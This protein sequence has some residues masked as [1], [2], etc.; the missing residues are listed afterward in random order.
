MK[1]L[2]VLFI[3]GT[4]NISA[5]S[6]RL[7]LLRGDEVYFVNRTL[8]A[9][10]AASGVK[11]IQCDVF[12]GQAL[13]AAVKDMHF[14]VVL[15]FIC[16]TLEH[17]KRDFEVFRDKVRQFFFISSCTVYQKQSLSE[18]ITEDVPLKNPYSDYAQNKIACELYFLERYR[19]DDFPVTIVRP[20][21]TYGETRFVV[22]PLM[23]WQVSHWTLVDRIL[24]GEPIIVHDTGRLFWTVT[25]SDDFAVG[26]CGLM[27]NIKAIGH[28]FHIT[29]SNPMSWNEIYKTYE[30]VLDRKVKLVHI[31][32]DF[33]AKKYPEVAQGIYGDM[34]E[35]GIF[36]NSKIKRF[37]Q[38]FADR[39]NLRQGLER[40]LKWH[41]AHPEVCTVSQEHNRMMEELIM[42]WRKA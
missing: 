33:I 9:E 15:D 22:G 20:S 41:Q 19:E 29:S 18:S 16:F 6:A 42:D 40:S 23:G 27:G 2:K 39:V 7:C 34:S 37:V 8:N 30:W 32:T 11:H 21:H 5:S 26:I 25:H 36:D 35:N 14:D 12:D 24:R 4:G 17:A 13:A 31:P 28:Q 3:G 1:I 10:F 38:D